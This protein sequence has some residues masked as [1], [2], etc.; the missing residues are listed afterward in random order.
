MIPYDVWAEI[1]LSAVARNV[2]AL[3]GALS[4]GARLMAVVKADGYGHGSV[5]V[6]RQVLAA[7][8]DCLAV[9][10]IGE[11]LELR[12]AGIQAPILIFGH[13]PPAL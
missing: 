5:P 8:A 1:D 4:P 11:A 2:R 6:A 7:G 9:A 10:R 12:Y 3:R 13:T